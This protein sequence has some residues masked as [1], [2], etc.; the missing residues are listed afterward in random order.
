MKGVVSSLTVALLLL[1]LFVFAFTVHL[2]R[3]ATGT[4]II[5]PNGSISSPVPANITTSDNVTYTFTGNNYLPIVVNRSS[6]RA[7]LR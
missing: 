7:T 1:S 6:A 2:A 5:N 3:A 4:I